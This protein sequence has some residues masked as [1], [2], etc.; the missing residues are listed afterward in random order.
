[1][2]SASRWLARLPMR[3]CLAALFALLSVP[4]G[5]SAET[6]RFYGYATHLDT[7][8]YLYTE[9]HEQT[10]ESGQVQTATISYFDPSGKL[11]A[12]KS[13]DYRRNRTI[14]LFRIDHPDQ[15][16]VEAL[17]SVN[18]ESGIELLKVT[19]DKGEQIKSVSMPK[20]AVAADSGFNHLI[21]DNLP[22]LLAGETVPFSLVV[23]GNLDAYQFRAKKIGDDTFDGAPAAVLRVEPDSLLR[24]IIDPLDLLYDPA[25]RR[26]LE[27]RG[28]S[29]ILDPVSGKVYKKARISY[30]AKPPAEAR[31]PGL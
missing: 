13:L 7:G 27:Y 23:A 21:Q 17:R 5:A 24:L 2:R 12:K 25:K 1:M 6:L 30:T 9:L 16:Y 26:L 8:K 14:P 19:R 22:R 4:V 11:M 20:G 18:G 15:G 28:V 29:N 31:A 10:L 3:P